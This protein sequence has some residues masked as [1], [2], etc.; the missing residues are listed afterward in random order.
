MERLPRLLSLAPARC[1]CLPRALGPLFRSHVERRPDPALETTLTA[2]GLVPLPQFLSHGEHRIPFPPHGGDPT[3]T[4][5]PAKPLLSWAGSRVRQGA[6]GQGVDGPVQNLI[7]TPLLV[8][9]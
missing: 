8:L 4:F 6:G 3:V 9:L 2:D 1:C 5:R 7:R